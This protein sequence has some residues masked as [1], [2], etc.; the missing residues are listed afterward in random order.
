M[1]TDIEIAQSATPRP[2]GEI[3]AMLGLD[4]DDIEM[5]GRYKAKVRPEPILA[6]SEAQGKLV[7]VT[8]ISPTSAGEGKSTVSVGL[9]DALQLMC[10]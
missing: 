3:A 8:G 6:R 10:Q 2:I 9:A 1:L 5:Y 7:L 4:G